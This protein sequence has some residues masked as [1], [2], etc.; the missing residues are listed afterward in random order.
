MTPDTASTAALS[1]VPGQADNAE[2]AIRSLQRIA[3]ELG[4]LDQAIARA[5]ALRDVSAVC[6]AAESAL[7]LHP[8]LAE[9][10]RTWLARRGNEGPQRPLREAWHAVESPR[11]DGQPDGQRSSL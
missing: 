7:D 3:S 4:L 5:A 9:A 2:A 6:T 8:R 10:Y 1:A 11:R